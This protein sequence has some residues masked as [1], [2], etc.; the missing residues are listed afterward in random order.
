MR[1]RV[2]LYVYVCAYMCVSM[3]ISID[4]YECLYVCL[5]AYHLN[6]PHT[7]MTLSMS[8]RENILARIILHYNS[9]QCFFYIQTQKFIKVCSCLKPDKIVFHF[10]FKCAPNKKYVL[11]NHLIHNNSPEKKRCSSRES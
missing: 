8:Q 7:Y 3:L 9:Y 11:Q 6:V 4:L 5:R 1:V 10:K 2:C